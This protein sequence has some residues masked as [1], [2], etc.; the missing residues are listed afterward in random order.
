[1]WPLKHSSWITKGGAVD[2]RLQSCMFPFQGQLRFCR[3]IVCAT[4]TPSS[5]VDFSSSREFTYT[6]THSHLPSHQ[7]DA[8]YCYRRHCC[9]CRIALYYPLIAPLDTV[10][11]VA[12]LPKNR[13]EKSQH[14]KA[15]LLSER[16]ARRHH[17]FAW[18]RSYFF[19][20]VI[21]FRICKYFYGKTP[22]SR[23]LYLFSV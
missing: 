6:Q 13:T 3:T 9:C 10:R 12:A 14:T 21:N 5:F 4:A 20:A 1:M 22:I 17:L 19:F 18:L 2:Y 11:S 16:C 7:L 8:R 23:S 15:H